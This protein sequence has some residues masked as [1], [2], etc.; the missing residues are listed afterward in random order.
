MEFLQIKTYTEKETKCNKCINTNI[1]QKYQKN[2]GTRNMDLDWS[3]DSFHIILY[4]FYL[5]ATFID[6][7]S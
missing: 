3:N 6:I 2:Y 5:Q 1:F 4:Y 7:S